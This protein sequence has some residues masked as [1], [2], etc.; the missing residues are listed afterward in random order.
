MAPRLQYCWEGEVCC[1]SWKGQ[2]SALAILWGDEASVYR[3]GGTREE[4]TVV[5]EEMERRTLHPIYCEGTYQGS[6]KAEALRPLQE[7]NSAIWAKEDQSPWNKDS[8]AFPLL[9]EIASLE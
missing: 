5:F 9:K 4:A 1:A 8:S 7:K 2:G 3:G 6:V